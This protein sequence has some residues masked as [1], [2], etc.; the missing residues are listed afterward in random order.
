MRPKQNP[1]S[2]DRCVKAVSK[3][4]S[5]ISPYAVCKAQAQ[6]RGTKNPGLNA[7]LAALPHSTLGKKAGAALKRY[8]STKNPADK[9]EEMYEMF[10]GMPPDEI[11]T[12]VERVHVHK[13]LWTVGTL[14]QMV[15]QTF[16][17]KQFDLD[18]PDPDEARDTEVV[19]V[20]ANEPYTDKATDKKIEGGTQMF[21]RGGDQEIPESILKSRCGFNHDDFKEQMIIGWVVDLT[22]RTKK[23]F[24][25]N[26]QELVDFVHPLGKE[27]SRGVFPLLVYKPRDPSMALFGGRYKVLPVRGD[28]G[29]SP[30]I[31][32]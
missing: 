29:A 27:H 4:G 30:G 7:M 3:S 2:F 15:I 20:T 11:L 31:A 18:A 16:N 24:E 17:G 25:K 5:A 12:I 21:F 32:G 9:S 6:R 28:I 26:G 19:Y 14:T 8:F 1:R 22:Y 10:H 23:I 13:N